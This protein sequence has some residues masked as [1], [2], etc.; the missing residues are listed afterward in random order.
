MLASP[1]S[2]HNRVGAEIAGGAIGQRKARERRWAITI[3]VPVGESTHGLRLRAE[4]RSVTI[5][6]S[7]SPARHTENDESAIAGMELGRPKPQRLQLAGSHVLDE[8][9]C[10]SEQPQHQF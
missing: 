3:T 6:S 9:V 1:E 8:D 7:L 2:R 10:A 5:R 4:G